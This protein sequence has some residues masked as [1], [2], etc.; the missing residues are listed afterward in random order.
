MNARCSAR[1]NATEQQQ[2]LQEQENFELRKSLQ[3]SHL[4][5]ASQTTK[6]VEVVEQA[7]ETGRQTDE[8][9]DTE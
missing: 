5:L 6:Q 1:L 7:A 3:H 9:T 4:A 8:W 2:Q